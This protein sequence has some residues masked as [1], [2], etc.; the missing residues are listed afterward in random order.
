MLLLVEHYHRFLLLIR[1]RLW[2]SLAMATADSTAL[3][4]GKFG[5]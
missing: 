5:K 4:T 3:I 1:L 2:S